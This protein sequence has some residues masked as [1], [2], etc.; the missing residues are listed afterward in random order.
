MATVGRPLVRADASLQALLLA[1]WA[2]GFLAVGG[3]E[4]RFLFTRREWMLLVLL[5]CAFAAGP[6]GVQRWL[7]W[8]L[9]Y[10]PVRL[11]DGRRTRKRQQAAHAITEQVILARAREL[12]IH[13]ALSVLRHPSSAASLNACT[14]SS[15]GVNYLSI[16]SKV[17]ELLGA[18]R[19]GDAGKHREFV[20]LIDHELGHVWNRDTS[21]L[22][23]ARA[24]LW[25]MVALLPLKIALVLSLN[26]RHVL[27]DFSSI[28]PPVI[29]G[30]AVF[31]N[32]D[33]P[34][35]WVSAGVFI[36]YLTA[37][38][39]LLGLCYRTLKRRRE[40]LADR[41]AYAHA[42]AKSEMREALH[43]LLAHPAPPGTAAASF[44]GGLTTHPSSERRL[45]R[46]E[47][48]GSAV[49][50]D[51]EVIITALGVLILARLAF[52]NSDRAAVIGAWSTVFI[53][54]SLPYSVAMSFLVGRIVSRPGEV[55]S[56][57][58]WRPLAVLTAS[59]CVAAAGL[60]AADLAL[61][62]ALGAGQTAAAAIT[63]YEFV[64]TALLSGSLPV[65]VVAYGL[66]H[67]AWPRSTDPPRRAVARFLREA[68]AWAGGT[69]LLAATSIA[70]TPPLQQFR[71]VSAER[72][73]AWHRENLGVER[74]CAGS[75]EAWFSREC[76]SAL[77]A[78]RQDQA[79]LED[80]FSAYVFRP[81]GA[82]V[83]LWQQPFRRPG[84]YT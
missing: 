68:A 1:T 75:R 3:V 53:L 80:Q 13:D 84:R 56:L 32:F 23:L 26:W 81:P 20:T 82:W 40:Y 10:P 28:L 44:M 66:F 11:I 41:F 24:V 43:R 71:A 6:L 48:P 37:T 14:W 16:T 64:E 21:V 34:P 22:Q 18:S 49:R 70:V 35:L 27:L 19:R 78:W 33:P 50:P 73:L 63:R 60:V 31:A 39:A 65:A 12:G 38:L 61:R 51:A 55:P 45:S 25:W 36:A 5:V 47:E 59:A 67:A 57:R 9:M 17:E 79:F 69:A 30:T 52:G 15:G 77:S 83:F 8:R 4:A 46:L 29:D 42:S 7:A 58:S 76:R 62:R 72:I 2:L 54:L 74:A